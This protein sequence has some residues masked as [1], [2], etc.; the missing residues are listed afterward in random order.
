MTDG[1]LAADNLAATRCLEC[2]IL[3]GRGEILCAWCL[4]SI[5]ENDWERLA[6]WLG[7]SDGDECGVWPGAA[8]EGARNPNATTDSRGCRAT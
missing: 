5:E 4:D 7:K 3:I 6:W 2:G 1:S 8:T